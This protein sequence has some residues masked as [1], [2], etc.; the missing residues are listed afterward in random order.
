MTVGA[1]EFKSHPAEFEILYSALKNISLEMGITMERTSRSPIFFSAHD[2]STAIFDKEGNLIT[3]TEYIPIHVCAASFAIRAALKYFGDDI[4]PGDVILLNDPYTYDGGNHI[5][6][7]TILLPVFWH[8][9]LWFWSVNRAHQMDTGGG[10][11]GGYNP[12]AQDCFAEGLR[13]PPIKIFEGGKLRKDVFDFVM[14]NVRFP[15]AQRGDL[16]S[17]IGSV[18][19]GERRLLGVMNMWGEEKLRKFL[20]DLIEYTEFLMRDE[21]AKV[22]DGTYYGEAFSDERTETDQF[23]TIRCSTTVKGDSI[24]IDLTGSDPMVSRYYNSTIANTYSSVFIALMTSI[25][26]HIKYRCEGVMTPV[27]IKTTPGTVVHA[28]YPAPHGLCTLMVAKQIIEAVWESLGQA[29]PKETPAG[30]GGFGSGTLTGI[31][32]RR[33]E[34]YATPDFL[35]VVAGGGAIG[36]TDGWHAAHSPISS[37]GLHYPEME[38][39]E[40]NVP[41][42]WKRW[43]FITD[44]G[45]AGKSRGGVGIVSEFVTETEEMQIS[46]LGDYYEVMPSAAVGGGRKPPTNCRRVIT[47]ANGTK[48]EIGREKFQ[49]LHTG[50]ILT[51]YAQGGCGVGSPLDRDS[52]KVREDVRNGIVSLE[53]ASEEYGVVID[54]KTLEVDEAQT[55]KLRLKNRSEEKPPGQ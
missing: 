28:T 37:G 55:R 19:V 32:P 10:V 54:S 36:D 33:N 45:G 52:E 14:G 16:W 51:C 38:V 6:D 30:W 43:G 49:T 42:L 21:L 13:I 22:P 4:N 40:L 46:Q 5:A 47:R 48:E 23:V 35:A 27:E 2:F 11:P 20:L 44:S 7:W 26:R 1:F 3:L 41:A 34:M 15:E 24:E 9:Q 17:M 39:M 29:I 25:G 50:D 12:D 8:D 18:R 53:K 31:D